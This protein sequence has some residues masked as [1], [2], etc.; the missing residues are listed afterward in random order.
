[1][2]GA[3]RLTGRCPLC[4]RRDLCRRRQHHLDARGKAQQCH[5]H[6]EQGLGAQ[7]AVH[8][9]SHGEPDAD[10]GKELGHH[11]PA[12]LDLGQMAFSLRAV[13]PFPTLRRAQSRIERLQPILVGL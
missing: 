4:L 7:Q 11:P 9:P 12:R 8:P 1:V 10:P 3:I 5:H 13:P 6:D 2:S